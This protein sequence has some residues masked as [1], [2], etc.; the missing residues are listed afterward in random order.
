MVIEKIEFSDHDNFMHS[1]GIRDFVNKYHLN[2]NPIDFNFRNIFGSQNEADSYYNTPRTWYGQKLFNPS[3]EQEPTSQNM[4]F[5]RKPEKKIAIEDVQYFLSSH[6]NGTKYDPFGTH[7]SGDEKDQKEIP[8]SKFYKNGLPEMLGSIK[9]FSVKRHD[10]ESLEQGIQQSR[11]E[12]VKAYQQ[13]NREMEQNGTVVNFQERREKKEILPK[14]DLKKMQIAKDLGFRPTDPRAYDPAIQKKQ[15]QKYQRPSSQ[16]IKRE[17]G[18][19]FWQ[20]LRLFHQKIH[21]YRK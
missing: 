21:I 11:F 18:P 13:Y 20:L 9:T 1:E 3:V 4:P 14:S 6:Y 10:I 19:D 7:S 5:C 15:K 16:Q 12:I 17:Y 2:P 8:F